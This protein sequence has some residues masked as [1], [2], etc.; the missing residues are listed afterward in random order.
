MNIIFRE[1]YWGALI[2]LAGV[3]LIIRNVF[4]VDLPVMGIIF[5]IF[6]ITLGVSLLS[7]FRGGTERHGKNILFSDDQF[8]AVNSDEHYSVV[9]GK[10]S[11]DLRTLK[12]VDKDINVDIS[13]AFGGVEILINPNIPMKIK[14]SSAFG[15]GQMPDGRTVAFGERVYK[16]PAYHD[17]SPSVNVKASVAF[18]GIEIRERSDS[19][20]TSN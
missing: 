20:S 6:I 19:T 10:G 14:V 8:D 16:S 11:Y 13:C 18:G 12:P 17:G 5:P 4:K 9:F 2:I 15:G 7:G 3:L 1:T